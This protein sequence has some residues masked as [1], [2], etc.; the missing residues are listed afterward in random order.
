[1]RN[2]VIWKG[3]PLCEGGEQGGD[4]VQEDD[5]QTSEG[6]DGGAGRDGTRF[7]EGGGGEGGHEPG[8]GEGEQGEVADQ[9]QG[10]QRCVR[11]PETSAG[12]AS[13]AAQ[14][15]GHGDGER[16]EEERGGGQARPCQGGDEEEKC[17][18]RLRRHEEGR[19]AAGGGRVLD[20]PPGGQPTHGGHETLERRASAHLADGGHAE[21]EGQEDLARDLDVGHRWKPPVDGPRSGAEADQQILQLVHQTGVL[22]GG[23]QQYW[24]AGPEYL[25][26]Q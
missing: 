8:H 1:M 12:D 14:D 3:T 6:A 13:A 26:Q 25:Y 7:G 10:A 18:P 21:D 22:P 24:Q 15:P 17:R 19:E 2:T 16:R 9:M 20:R 23:S 4:V 5:D 11:G